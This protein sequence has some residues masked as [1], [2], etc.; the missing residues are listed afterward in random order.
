[1]LCLND[2]T[3]LSRRGELLKQAR[4][5]VANEGYAFKKSVHVPKPMVMLRQQAQIKEQSVTRK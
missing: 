1:M 2:P 3:L 4:S 5:K